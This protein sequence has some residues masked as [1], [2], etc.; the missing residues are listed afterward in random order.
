M[1]IPAVSVF[2]AVINIPADQPTL[3]AGVDVATDGDTI[4]VA[5]GIYSGPGNQDVVIDSRSL[6]LL[7]THGRDSTIFIL[8]SQAVGI[9]IDYPWESE[10]PADTVYVDG[11][12][13]RDGAVAISLAQEFADTRGATRI[14]RCIF[15]NNDI[16]VEERPTF[17]SVINQKRDLKSDEATRIQIDSS[18]FDSNGVG[19][20][21]VGENYYFLRASISNCTFH[22]NDTAF[23]APRSYS[24]V[25]LL[26][27][28]LFENNVRALHGNFS[29]GNSIIRSNAIAVYGR[30]SYEPGGWDEAHLRDCIIENTTDTVIR[31]GYMAHLERCTVRNN[32]GVFFAGSIANSEG[33]SELSLDSCLIAGNAGPFTGRGAIKL[34]ATEYTGNVFG[35]RTA[36]GYGSLE[37]NR[38]LFSNN[39]G[40]CI[41]LDKSIGPGFKARN[42]PSIRNSTFTGNGGSAVVIDADSGFEVTIADCIMA[43]NNG[44]GINNVSV[45]DIPDIL[46]SCSDIFNNALGN[47][48][49]FDDQTGLDGNISADPLFCDTASGD[50]SLSNLSACAPG[51]N[52]CGVLMGALGITCLTPFIYEIKIDTLGDSMHVLSEWPLLQWRYDHVAGLQAEF[53][54][55]AGIDNDWTEAEMWAPVPFVSSDTFLVYAGT[56]LLDGQTYYLRLRY[57]NGQDWSDWKESSFRMN[58]VPG[59]PLPL[60]P[61]DS[62]VVNLAQPTFWWLDAVDD[63]DDTLTYSIELYTDTLQPPVISAT[64]II[65]TPDSTAWTPETALIDNQAYF[66]KIRAGDSFE[67]SSW[68]AFRLCTVNFEPN[69]PLEF[70]AVCPPFDSAE[71]IYEML[72]EF[73][74]TTAV[75][76]DPSDSVLYTL[77]LAM[78][79]NFIF[80]LEID[81]LPDTSFALSDSLQFGHEYWWKIRATDKT[82]LFTFSSN[83]RSFRTW[84][85]GDVNSDWQFDVLDIIFVTDYKFRDGPAPMPFFTADTN[86]DCRV[87]ILDIIRMV[88]YK[89]KGG[90]PIL[91]GCEE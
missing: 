6:Y 25:A 37:I 43:F 19:L 72:P 24:I 7:S 64:G 18:A 68:S 54:I 59:V 11:F 82:G 36:T 84:L 62:A 32:D 3:Q 86:G 90:P 47:Y 31:I 50:F 58:S 44:Y 5:P 91:P 46:L 73:C 79:P 33:F 1:I 34:F 56:P 75:E 63:N 22:Y 28:C 80:T 17:K 20:L 15:S 35:I 41:Y 53:E 12:T 26:D 74:W 13:F 57:F 14:S 67:N 55:A 16:A 87:N 71:V 30:V 85:L 60:A 38:C 27:S 40:D 69:A 81:S 39:S 61:P 88:D 65:E 76:T 23:Y 42:Y 89:F 51:N 9:F 4:L 49:G 77:I 70:L 66:W 52:S 48:A 10:L 78:E 29:L 8:E 2:S 21:L 45:A 83:I